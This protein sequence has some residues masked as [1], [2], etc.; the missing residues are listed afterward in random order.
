[1]VRPHIRAHLAI[2][3]LLV[4]APDAI[5]AGIARKVHQTILHDLGF[6]LD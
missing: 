2:L 3:A 4:T 5:A 6:L 1:M